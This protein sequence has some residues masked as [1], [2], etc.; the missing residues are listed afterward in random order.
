MEHQGILLF[1]SDVK[2][3]QGKILP[4]PY[5]N[6][7]DCYTT[8]ESAVRY[9]VKHHKTLERIFVFATKKVKSILLTIPE[10]KQIKNITMNRADLYPHVL[11]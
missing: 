1:L 11:F 7:G 4:S 6:I 9:C 2:V 10:E 8:N 5:E 3:T